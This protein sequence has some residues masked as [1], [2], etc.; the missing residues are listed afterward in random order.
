MRTF[1]PFAAV[2]KVWV[3]LA[4]Q[5]SSWADYRHSLHLQTKRVRL[6]KADA[7]GHEPFLSGC[8]CSERRQ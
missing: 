7:Q 6:N 4:Q 2:A 3:V 8:R 1:L 5:T